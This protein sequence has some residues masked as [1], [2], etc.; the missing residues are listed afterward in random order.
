MGAKHG[1]YALSPVHGRRAAALATRA[2]A[3]ATRS[4]VRNSAH[5]VFCDLDL[6]MLRLFNVRPE[7]YRKIGDEVSDVGTRPTM[8]GDLP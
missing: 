8:R 1:L 3:T 7:G 6:A 4:R 2:V 5:R